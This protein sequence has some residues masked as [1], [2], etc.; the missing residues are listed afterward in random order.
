MWLMFEL[1]LPV[2]LTMHNAHR[3]NCRLW[4]AADRTEKL[5]VLMARSLGVTP[6]LIVATPFHCFHPVSLARLQLLLLLLCY[7]RDK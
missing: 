7:R 3:S 1:L 6:N 2:V 5:P 4:I